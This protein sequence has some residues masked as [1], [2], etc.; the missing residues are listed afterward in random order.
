MIGTLGAKAYGDDVDDA[1]VWS[2]GNKPSGV[3]KTTAN[4]ALA[5][6]T[7]DTFVSQD[8]TGIVQEIVNRAGWVSG[9]DMRFA[10]LN[11]GAVQ[12]YMRFDDYSRAGTN[13]AILEV[14]FAAASSTGRGLTDSVLLSGRSLVA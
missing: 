10:L 14:T 3:T 9:N 8:V 4:T 12:G 5:F 11:T 1:A 13:H 6:G 7:N 2:A